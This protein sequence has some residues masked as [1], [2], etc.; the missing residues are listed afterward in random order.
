MITTRNLDQHGHKK[1]L[2]TFTK[3]KLLKEKLNSDFTSQEPSRRRKENLKK[4]RNYSDTRT[5]RRDA[6]F[7]LRTSHLRPLKLA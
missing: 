1:P 7:T 2:M 6:T 3:K 4:R 5:Q